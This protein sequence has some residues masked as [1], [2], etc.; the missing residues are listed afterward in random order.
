MLLCCTGGLGYGKGC[1]PFGIPC[2]LLHRFPVFLV[3]LAD[4]PSSLPLP[5]FSLLCYQAYSA[6]GSD[7]DKA[8]AQIGV[9]THQ[10]MLD[11]IENA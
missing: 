11:A 5:L 10:A 6:A 8:L 2:L 3:P 9:E 1:D 4:A 7:E